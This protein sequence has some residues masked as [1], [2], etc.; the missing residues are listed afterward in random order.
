MV[1]LGRESQATPSCL[2]HLP[3]AASLTR[4]YPN[5][6]LSVTPVVSEAGKLSV[7]SA[8]FS[9]SLTGA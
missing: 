6:V 1:K 7:L 3:V 2:L 5:S 4:I 9:K 8:V